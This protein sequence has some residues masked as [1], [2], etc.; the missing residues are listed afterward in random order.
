[1]ITRLQYVVCMQNTACEISANVKT[2]TNIMATITDTSR[3]SH[4]GG[5]GHYVGLPLDVPTFLDF[6]VRALLSAV[7]ATAL[8]HCLSLCVSLCLVVRHK[9]V[10]Y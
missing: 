5:G 7:Y 6:T 9:S 8:C 2:T 4:I 10:F 3:T 1:M